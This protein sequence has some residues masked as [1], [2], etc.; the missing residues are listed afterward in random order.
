LGKFITKKTIF[1][2]LEATLPHFLTH[3]DE[4]WHEG[5]NLG[6]PPQAKFCKKKSLKGVLHVWAN[7]YRKLQ[8]SAIFAV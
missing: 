3:S 4:I 6:L 2:I 8:I 1:A 7:L 5:A